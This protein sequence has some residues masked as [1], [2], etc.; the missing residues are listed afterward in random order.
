MVGD[1]LLKNWY[2]VYNYLNAG[3]ESSFAKAV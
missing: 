1:T 2:S 3:G